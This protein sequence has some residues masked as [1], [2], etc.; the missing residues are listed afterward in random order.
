MMLFSILILGCVPDGESPKPAPDGTTTDSGTVDSPPTDTGTS[1]SDSSSTT[2]TGPPVDSGDSGDSGSTTTPEDTGWDFPPGMVHMIGE[3]RFTVDA[4]AVVYA[5]DGWV[6]VN[7]RGEALCEL[8]GELEDLG[9][10][11]AGCPDCAW[12]FGAELLQVAFA[13]DRCE[14]LAFGDEFDRDIEMSGAESQVSYFGYSA[15]YADPYLDFPMYDVIWYVRPPDVPEWHPW[16][17]NLSPGIPGYVRWEGNTLIAY[18]YT[19]YFYDY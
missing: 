8:M 12:T 5:E 7:G 1:I 16:W 18:S 4:G 2:D 19:P 10:V 3:T 15:Y 9:S 13:G 6:F 11:P 17:F 14:E